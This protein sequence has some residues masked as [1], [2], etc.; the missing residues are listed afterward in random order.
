VAVIGVAPAFEGRAILSAP[1]ILPL[2]RL[3]AQ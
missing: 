3:D 2:T 1:P